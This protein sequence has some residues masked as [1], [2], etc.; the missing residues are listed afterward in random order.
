MDITISGRHVDITQAMKDH[1]HEKSA[2][3]LRFWDRLERVGVTLD[4]DNTQQVAEFVAVGPKGSKF[5]ARVAETDMYKSIDLAAHKVE[6]QLKRHHEKLTNGKIRRRRK[7][8]RRLA[9]ES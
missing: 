5:V 1:A 3:L 9:P 7:A 8:E 6:R 4:V 2:L